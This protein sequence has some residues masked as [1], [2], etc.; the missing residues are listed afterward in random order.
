M[1]KGLW[2]SAQI[3]VAA[4]VAVLVWRA[5]ARNWTEFRSL[6]VTLA[7]KAGPLA[8]SV[9]AVMVTYALQIESWRRILAGWA[10]HL[11]YGKAARI[12][13]LVNL[14]R[15]VP[16]K[17]WSVAGLIVLAQRAG[18]EPWAAGASAF[19]IQAVG[20]G[21]AV[22]V[23]AAATPGAESPLRLAA[24]ALVATATIGF[25]AWERG[26]RWLAGLAGRGGGVGRGSEFKPP[27]P[28][29]LAAVA[30]SAGLTLASWGSYGLA[31]WLL[32]RGLGLP[33]SLSL[34][35]AAGVFAL[36][37]ILGLLA[38][39][40]PGGVGVRELVFIG[41]LTPALGSGG[42]VALSVGSRV[43]LTLCEAAA[44]LG[45]LLVTGRTKE[46]MGVRT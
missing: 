18:V 8:L 31:F 43:L 11:P 37:Y 26:T 44:P 29:P 10:Q 22:A 33:G 38:L 45:V 28:L 27:K 21:T 39:F 24:A 41:L 30:E 34:P 35:T 17:V 32:A 9:L 23:V 42:A 19:A 6:H 46:D 14:G 1:R 36:G 3:A 2:W 12:W 16:G 4:V 40:A 20:L 13:L 7:L 5:A 15:Y 25:L